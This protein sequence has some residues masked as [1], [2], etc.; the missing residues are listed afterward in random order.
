MDEIAL[1]S[2]NSLQILL[3]RSSWITFYSS[4][5]SRFDFVS[6][7]TKEYFHE[8]FFFCCCKT[9]LVVCYFEQ[10][11]G[12]IQEDF[13]L[14]ITQSRLWFSGIFRSHFAFRFRFSCFFF[15]WSM[16]VS[17]A[18]CFLHQSAKQIRNIYAHHATEHGLLT[19]DG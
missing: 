13:H 12:N 7:P 11:I 19:L 5:E 9:E 17:T 1:Y 15:D 8:L 14:S 18:H 2:T 3:W 10:Y 16:V 4:W 6:I